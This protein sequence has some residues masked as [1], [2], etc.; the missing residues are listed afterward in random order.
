[1]KKFEFLRIRFRTQ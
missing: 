1:M